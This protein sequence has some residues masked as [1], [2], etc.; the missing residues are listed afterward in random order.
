[1][2]VIHLFNKTPLY[3]ITVFQSRSDDT[4]ST[5]V[6]NNFALIKAQRST[7]RQFINITNLRP[8]VGSIQATIV[9]TWL[10]T[11][12]PL[13][14]ILQCLKRTTKSWHLII[15]PDP[16]KYLAFEVGLLFFETSES[17]L[18]YLKARKAGRCLR[19]SDEAAEQCG[20]WRCGPWGISSR[21]AYNRVGGLLT[22]IDSESARWYA[23]RSGVSNSGNSSGPGTATKSLS[24]CPFIS[25]KLN[26]LIYQPDPKWVRIID[27]DRRNAD[28]QN[29]RDV[30]IDTMNKFPTYD[31]QSQQGSEAAIRDIEQKLSS[32]ASFKHEIVRK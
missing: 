19:V 14:Q 26:H 2:A 24:K 27:T 16:R 25:C 10:W 18:N 9:A 13:L 4:D 22:S 1:M 20:P 12:N 5:S 11:M 28:G 3:F 29:V 15:E 30:L 8:S 7:P 21:Y 6:G 31:L 23:P 32:V 17:W